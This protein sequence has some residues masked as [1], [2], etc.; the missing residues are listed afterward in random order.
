MSKE[1]QLT[2]VGSGNTWRP[3][4]KLVDS[5][6]DRVTMYRL[7]EYYLI[8]LLV[9]AVGLSLFGD[10]NYNPVYIVVSALILVVSC[11]AI[12]RVFAFLFDAP[13]NG[14]S[15][16]LTGLILSLIIA[17]DPTGYGITFVLAAAGLAISS[18]YLLAINRRHIFNPAAVAVVLTALGPRQ[19]ASWWVGTAVMVPF[20][21]LGG[22]L[23]MRKTRREAMILTFFGSA[24]VASVIYTALSG[25]DA[26]TS[27]KQLLLSSAM[28]FLG[29]V[30]LTEPMTSPTSRTKQVWYA[31]LVGFLLPPQAQ[32]FNYY[33]SPELALVIGN[34]FSY[35]VSPKAKLFPVLK[36][37]IK[38][39]ANTVDFVFHTGRKFS[40]KPGQYMEWTLPHGQADLRGSRRFLTLAS[41]PT[42]PDLRIGVKF[43]EPGSTFKKALIDMDAN[44]PIVASQI[45]GD[46]TL[47]EDKNKKLAFIAGGIGVTPFRSMVKYLMDTNDPRQVTLLYGANSIAD[48]AYADIFTQATG[49][50]GLKTV[51]VLRDV[52]GAPGGLPARSGMVNAQIIKEEIPDYAERLFYLSGT[53]VMVEAVRDAL[54]ELGVHRS[55]IKEDFFPGYV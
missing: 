48:V 5:Y 25:G 32:L 29:F 16:I 8:G 44:T 20:V 4:F 13:I 33:S 12:N 51:Y 28:F 35:I 6:I 52:A 54:G 55:H 23:I 49:Q 41:S 14:E 2:P 18:K 31:G 10:L 19:S 15:S 43:Y 27:L 24:I 39:A 1:S 37:K 45:A 46:F 47:P 53:H 7:L 42:E 34:V 9:V 21:L 11:W 17:P 36:Q 30:M 50:I 3:M 40:Y 22:L 38:V 26:M